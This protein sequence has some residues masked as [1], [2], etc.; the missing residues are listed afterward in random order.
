MFWVTLLPEKSGTTT[1]DDEELPTV[2]PVVKFLEKPAAAAVVVVPPVLR[3]I[4]LAG[5]LA[6]A[7]DVD[8]GAAAA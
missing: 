3:L 2:A 4:T 8:A 5:S 7:T 1:L 6:A